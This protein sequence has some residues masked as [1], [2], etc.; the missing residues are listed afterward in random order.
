MAAVDGLKNVP[1]PK[2]IDSVEKCVDCSIGKLKKKS[3]TQS[4]KTERGILEMIESDTQGPFRVLAVDGT[5]N[6]VKFIDRKSGYVK[7]ETIPDRE[8]ETVLEVFKRFQA[9]MER[10]TGKKIQYVATDGGTEYQKEFLSYLEQCGITK[11]KGY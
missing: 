9:R 11:M 4:M 6:N 1:L 5:R 2:N 3:S 8:A 10:R 7:M